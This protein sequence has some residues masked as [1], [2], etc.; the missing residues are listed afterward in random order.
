MVVSAPVTVTVPDGEEPLAEARETTETPAQTPLTAA[1]RAA[2]P[3]NP[4]RTAVAD[5]LRDIGHQVAQCG[6]GVAGV[7]SARFVFESSGQVVNLS[8]ENVP[9]EAQS[10]IEAIGYGEERPLVE[11]TTAERRKMNRRIEFTLVDES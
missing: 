8:V 9:P 1:E 11:N 5:E 10:C 4:S 3:Q 6:H 7:A 2:L